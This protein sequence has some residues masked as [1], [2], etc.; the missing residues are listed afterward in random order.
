MRVLVALE[1]H[2]EQTPDGQVWTQAA[3]ASHFWK[4]FLNVFDR[5][6]VVARVQPIPYDLP[7]RLRADGDNIT[8]SALPNYLGPLQY[9][10]RS[11]AIQNKARSAFQRGDAV[12]LRVPSAVSTALLPAVEK[13]DYPYALQVGG[14]PHAVFSRGVVKHPLRIVWQYWF[15]R[16]LKHQCAHA[17]AAAYVTKAYLQKYYPCPGFVTS[18][19]DVE[20]GA[21]AFVQA[22]HPPPQKSGPVRLV[23]IASLAQLYK[24]PD[25]LMQAVGLCRAQG[26]DAELVIIGDGKYRPTLQMLAQ[27]L[28]LQAHIHF[29][30]QLT[31]GAPVRAQFDRAD[32]FVLPSRT[33]G[34]PRAMLEAMAR[35]LPC[36]GSTVGGIPEL[37]DAEDLVPPGDAAALA[38]KLGEMVNNPSRMTLMAQRNLV[39]ANE[40]R[41][42][43]LQ[44]KANAFYTYVREHTAHWLSEHP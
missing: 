24:A 41:Q 19:S 30:G 37:L 4:R 9:L 1:H 20:L 14:D 42:E 36:I 12:I 35:G 27:E 21:D 32:V 39:R 31:A 17:A 28:G 3:Y 6:Q 2:F 43:K 44:A 33:E 25:I 38:H 26:I 40:F 34:L 16:Q 11:R 18:F 15:T 7:G 5:V 8:F 10:R 13:Q 22:P 23:T 29:L